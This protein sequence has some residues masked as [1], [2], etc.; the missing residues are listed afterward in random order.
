MFT[1]KLGIP[2]LYEATE[3]SMKEAYILM[4]TLGTSLFD[5]INKNKMNGFP[6]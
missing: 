3:V 1:F 5:I 6:I 2:Y 4:E